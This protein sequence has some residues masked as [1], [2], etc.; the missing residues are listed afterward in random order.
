[1]ANYYVLVCNVTLRMLSI[2]SFND[3]VVQSMSCCE[4]TASV[5]AAASS[6]R[7]SRGLRCSYGGYIKQKKYTFSTLLVEC[8]YEFKNIIFHVP[9]FS[10]A[11]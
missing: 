4:L 9:S 5:C 8:N 10:Y 3:C 6:T 1:M 7:R 11:A 2:V